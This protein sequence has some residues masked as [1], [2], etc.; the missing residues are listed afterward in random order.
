MRVRK[1]AK[2]PAHHSHELLAHKMAVFKRFTT[3]IAGRF[4]VYAR[5]PSE[6]EEMRIYRFAADD[7]A[8][9]WLLPDNKASLA[10][11][12][13]GGDVKY[14]GFD[15]AVVRE[16]QMVDTVIAETQG[17]NP[18]EVVVWWEARLDANR[19]SA[20]ASVFPP[21]PTQD[22]PGVVRVRAGPDGMFTIPPPPRSGIPGQGPRRV[23][24]RFVY[25]E[26]PSSS[27]GGDRIASVVVKREPADPVNDETLAR[28]IAAA[29]EFAGE[30][31]MTVEDSP[32]SV[33]R[34]GVVKEEPD[35]EPP[36]GPVTSV[37]WI[38]DSDDDAYL[39]NDLEETF[40]AEV[41][42]SE[43]DVDAPGGVVVAELEAPESDMDE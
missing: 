8:R 9:D 27:S 19:P 30:G 31:P 20:P 34:R 21:S 22:E 7:V 6:S 2:R 42:A 24:P 14:A 1:V 3:V 26:T 41:K 37:E 28:S 13:R 23:R 35:A 36:R 10:A 38:L 5:P 17:M 25:P 18:D 11:F 4:A 32:V 43:T 39:Q 33:R 16:Q 29:E 15:D 12:K 40:A